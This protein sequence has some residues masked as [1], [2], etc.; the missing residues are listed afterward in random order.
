MYPTF[1]LCF[2]ADLSDDA[3]DEVEVAEADPSPPF[4]GCTLGAWK[5]KKV[6]R[7]LRYLIYSRINV[8]FLVLFY[9]SIKPRTMR[10]FLT[11]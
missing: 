10:S 4:W 3:L 7:L 1:C 5:G 9:S 11:Q 2:A 8:Y 6:G